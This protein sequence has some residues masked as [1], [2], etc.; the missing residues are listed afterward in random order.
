M[1]RL[2]NWSPNK[3]SP[4]QQHPK[5]PRCKG[6]PCNPG[7]WK[8]GSSTPTAVPWPGRHA[9][10]LVGW[11]LIR[12]HTGAAT[13][14]TQPQAGD[15]F[16]LG[17][18]VSC[19]VPRAPRAVFV[20]SW[21]P[22][23]RRGH[24]VSRSHVS[25]CCWGT[26]H[27]HWHCWGLGAPSESLP[28]YSGPPCG[29]PSSAPSTAHRGP[30]PEQHPRAL[31][32]R[33]AASRG[34]PPAPTPASKAEHPP[35]GQHCRARAST[36]GEPILAGADPSTSRVRAPQHRGSSRP[37]YPGAPR[38]PR[39]LGNVVRGRLA[40]LVGL[41]GGEPTRPTGTSGVCPGALPGALATPSITPWYPPGASQPPRHP[42]WYPPGA[43][44]S[45][46]IP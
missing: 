17:D 23:P 37:P 36:R 18:T 40:G 43:S 7:S 5:P 30:C 32:W 44:A 2:H 46:G 10:I 11:R 16:L 3:T 8:L 31:G 6:N 4:S 38:D 26:S 24:R 1:L 29:H 27:A 21:L 12:S 45:V 14:H 28:P 41:V 34:A 13:P 25:L 22:L 15:M 20:K 42:S 19:P 35:R 33:G 39:S 9:I